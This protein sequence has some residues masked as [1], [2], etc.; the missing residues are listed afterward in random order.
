[1]GITGSH[2]MYTIEDVPGKGKGLIATKD[3]PKGT[4]I[5]SE[6][7]VVNSGEDVK[8]TEDLRVRIWQQVAYLSEAQRQEFT[9]M[10]NIH[11]YT[12]DTQRYFGIFRTNALPMGPNL[13]AGGV[14]LKACRINHS[15][16]SNAQNFWNENL[17]Q[18]TIHASKDIQNGEE[19]TICYLNDKKNRE[20]RQGQLLKN[21]SF[22]CYC[23]VCS[24]PPEQSRNND[25]KLDRIKEIDSIIAH[26][27]VEGLVSPALRMLSFID[28]QVQ[29]WNDPAPNAV[30]LA[31]AY[32]DAFE[33]AV[34]NGDLARARVFAERLVPLYQITMGNDSPDVTKYRELTRNPSL[35]KYYGMSK[36][37]ET[38]VDEVPQL[39]DPA[40]F[41]DWLWRRNETTRRLTG[42]RDRK[43]FPGF[44][45]LPGTINS[46]SEFFDCAD[47]AKRQPVRHWCFLAKI[48]DCAL[49]DGV[50]LVVR[51]VDGMQATVLLHFNDKRSKEVYAGLR[52]ESTVA[53]L[54]AMRSASMFSEPIMLLENPRMMK[55]RTY[56][57]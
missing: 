50:R 31:R 4:R 1:M 19:I 38:R 23:Q 36:K 33:I 22:T 8:N 28:E 45:D 37:W 13:A 5:I 47:L 39:L 14:F 30:G 27:G 20:A 34:A 12:N 24:L 57:L 54:Y 53:I 56:G 51:D 7:P 29:H 21:F 46:G 55:V 43:S 25:L 35:H 40:A 6:T 48:E 32:P 44:Y 11:P 2:P 3:I 26:E 10:A 41:E 16:D 18:L 17:N 52:K 9:S 49:F 42:F 15:C